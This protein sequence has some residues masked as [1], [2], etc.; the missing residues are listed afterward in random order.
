MRPAE[1]SVEPTWAGQGSC[2]RSSKW[3]PSRP[4]GAQLTRDETVQL[5]GIQGDAVDGGG[6]GRACNGDGGDA[7][8]EGGEARAWVGNGGDAAAGDGEARACYGYIK[9]QI[10]Y[11]FHQ[12]KC[13]IGDSGNDGPE[14]KIRSWIQTRRKKS[15]PWWRLRRCDKN[16]LQEP[17]SS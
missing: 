8:A 9:I 14:A 15:L 5:S 7:A 3:R 16:I 6:K 2:A 12:E 10:L 11:N 1:G 4:A 17:N 13:P